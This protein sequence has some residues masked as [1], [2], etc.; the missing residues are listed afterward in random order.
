M[1]IWLELPPLCS[2]AQPR[3]SWEPSYHRSGIRLR[4]LSS[5][6]NTELLSSTLPSWVLTRVLLPCVAGTNETSSEFGS[7]AEE[8]FPLC[9]ENGGMRTP[10]LEHT[11]SGQTVG[12]TALYGN[13]KST[14]GRGG[15]GGVFAS[16]RRRRCAALAPA[17]GPG[18]ASLRT[19]LPPSWIECRVQTLSWGVSA[20]VS[21]RELWSKVPGVAPRNAAPCEPVKLD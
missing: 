2:A 7:E 10:T 18:T 13:R 17:P 19:P 3:P 12:G 6:T 4:C 1:A 21:Y 20:A 5:A 11:F 15:G 8:R 16:G 9:S 14:A